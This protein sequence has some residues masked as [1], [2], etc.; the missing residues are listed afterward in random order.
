MTLTTKP[1]TSWDEVYARARSAAPEAFDADRIANLAGG[2]WQRIGD[3]GEHTTPVDGSRLQG[4][5]RISHDQAV[6]AVS[7]AKREHDAWQSVDLD[8]RKS[9][10]AEAVAG[11]R[12]AA[13]RCPGRS[14]TSRRGTTR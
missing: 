12:E 11:M 7:Y 9:R 13:G 10:V 3:P 1:G 8:E 5:P 14:A 6:E 4:P 2:E